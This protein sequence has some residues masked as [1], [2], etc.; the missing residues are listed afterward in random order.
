MTV[1]AQAI[2]TP[3][4]HG[5]AP[6]R[7]RDNVVDTMRGVAILMVIGIHAL[8]KAD[9]APLVIAIDAALR[10]CVP[11]FLFV[12]G[13]LTAQSGV[14]PLAKRLRRTIGPYTVAFIAA[15]IFMAIDN[16]A[17]DHRPA[18]AVARYALAYVFVYYYVFVYVGC[19]VM[20]WA[21]FALAGSRANRT[22]QL[23]VIL[24]LA[25]L[26]GLVCGAYIDPLLQHL[27]VTGSIIEEVRM[28]DLPF[29]FAFMAVGAL[30]GL[31]QA[32]DVFRALRYPLAGAAVLAYA[33][34][35]AVRIAGIG[36]AADYDSLA[37]FLY[38]TLLC[39][40]LIGFAPDNFALAVLGSASYFIYLW[41][42]FVIMV[43]RQL[44]ALQPHPVVS[45]IV[46]YGAAL[47]VSAALVLLLRRLT[48][49]RIAHG[50]GA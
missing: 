3:V 31:F 41:H 25:M 24:M 39:I 16:P 20:L 48:P 6:A 12:S 10:P 45:T 33:V 26:V 4:A 46:E 22:A 19:S 38:A 5:R 35:A 47:F 32:G 14:V 9:G 40:A 7:A 27:G 30:A 44:P 11:I 50:L 15:Y 23:A 17:M 18:V 43:L 28:R 8:P 36:D 29:W 2:W 37:F 49:P 21:A 42:I 1:S 34:Y 13:Y